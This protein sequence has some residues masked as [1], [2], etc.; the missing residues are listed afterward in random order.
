M[1]QSLIW[2]RTRHVLR[3]RSA[4][5]EYFP[6]AIRAFEK[7]DAPETLELLAAAPDPN[8]AAKLTKA[9]VVAALTRAH[10]RNLD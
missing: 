4:L 5:R 1:H 9:R 3:L 10:R 2:D 7:L 8:Q 6:A